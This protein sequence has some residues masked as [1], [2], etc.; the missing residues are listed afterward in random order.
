[1]C[2]TSM[3]SWGETSKLKS[4]LNRDK[5]E[6]EGEKVHVCKKDPTFWRQVCIKVHVI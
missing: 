1:M 6:G 3:R 5:L 4:Q 2:T